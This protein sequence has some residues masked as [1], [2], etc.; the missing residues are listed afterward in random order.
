MGLKYAELFNF[1]F[2]AARTGAVYGAGGTADHYLNILVH[3]AIQAQ[4]VRLE[5]GGDHGFEFVHAMDA[6][7]GI[8]R[9]HTA[10][11]LKYRIYNVGTGKN[12]TLT[13]LAAMIKRHLPAADFQIGRGLLPHLPQRGPFD[14]TRLS[15]LGY[16]PRYDLEEGLKQ[17]ID[18]I[19]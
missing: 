15:R 19:R 4:P 3:S 6:A 13:Q 17:Y 2:A 14:I 16:R 10:A 11:E 9:I 7:E 1:E 8:R 12:H 5:H 18:S